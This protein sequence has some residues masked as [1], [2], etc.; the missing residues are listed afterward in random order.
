MSSMTA[1]PRA[2]ELDVVQKLDDLAES[3]HFVVAG[4]LEYS[5]GVEMSAENQQSQFSSTHLL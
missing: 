1:I 3:A 2:P 4:L 5:V